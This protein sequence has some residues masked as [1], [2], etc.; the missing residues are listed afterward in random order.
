MFPIIIFSLFALCIC[1]LEPRFS[2]AVM[3]ELDRLSS[4]PS[5]ISTDQLLAGI[6]PAELAAFVASAS[7]DNSNNSQPNPITK[8][9][10]NMTTG[11]VNGSFVVLPLDYD[12][13]RAII[14][15]K[16]GILRQ[17]IKAVL[18]F[19]PEDKYPVRN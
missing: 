11:T 2:A 6:S 16:Y 5:L 9:F 4:L 14:P 7:T 10:A 17:S 3:Q 13:A 19:F 1:K 15:S 8:T 12:V 18:P